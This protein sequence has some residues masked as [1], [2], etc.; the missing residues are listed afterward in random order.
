MPPVKQFFSL[1]AVVNTRGPPGIT[2]KLHQWNLVPLPSRTMPQS[3]VGKWRC[4]LSPLGSRWKRRICKSFNEMY[5][6]EQLWGSKGSSIEHRE[7]TNWD[8]VATVASANRSKISNAWKS[9]RGVLIETRSLGLC[10]VQQWPCAVR[11]W[12]I[13]ECGLPLGWGLNP[14][15]AAS[16]VR[17]EFSEKDIVLSSQQPTLP[18]T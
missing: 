5:S 12:P 6:Q 9:S 13:T 17:G 10:T 3:G 8:A 4:L 18:T 2:E 15:R 14:G 7:W 1:W 16:F 11:Q